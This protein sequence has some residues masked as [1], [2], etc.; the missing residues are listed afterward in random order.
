LSDLAPF[1]PP[2]IYPVVWSTNYMSISGESDIMI[3]V[4]TAPNYYHIDMLT[5]TIYL[6][7]SD[8]SMGA[9]LQWEN[10]TDDHPPFAT[11]GITTTADWDGSF[12]QNATWTNETAF[13]TY[14]GIRVQLNKGGSGASYCAAAA[15]GYYR[16]VP[17][18]WS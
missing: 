6:D 14:L 10:G 18:D 15:T 7:L 11:L 4:P 12:S 5:L 16:S 13:D 8:I 2:D 3:P 9:E 17:G 1:N